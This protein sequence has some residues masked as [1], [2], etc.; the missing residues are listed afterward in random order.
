MILTMGAVA[1]L[2][3][4]IDHEDFDTLMDEPAPPSAPELMDLLADLYDEFNPSAPMPG[5]AP[6][7]RACYNKIS[8]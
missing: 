6:Q 5:P 1:T 8:S 3:K 2:A 4:A 7:K